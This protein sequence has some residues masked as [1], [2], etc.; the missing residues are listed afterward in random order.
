MT[1][2]KTHRWERVSDGKDRDEI[3]WEESYYGKLDFLTPLF[4]CADGAKVTYRIARLQ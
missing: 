4:R 1:N 3:S 2:G